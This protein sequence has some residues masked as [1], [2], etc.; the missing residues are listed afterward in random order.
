MKHRLL[1]SMI[2]LLIFI[3]C[4]LT[5][6]G[7]RTAPPATASPVDTAHFQYYVPWD[8][9]ADSII[10]YFEFS[11]VDPGT[12][13]TLI[14]G[15]DTLWPQ[16]GQLFAA[17]CDSFTAWITGAYSKDL[18]GDSIV[19][20]SNQRCRF[21]IE[22]WQDSTHRVYMDSLKGALSKKW[23]WQ[24]AWVHI[25]APQCGF[26]DSILTVKYAGDTSYVY[27]PLKRM[28]RVNTGVISLK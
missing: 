26:T 2:A 14:V 19:F 5:T 15:S 1:L 25:T 22:D 27:Y 6:P 23:P 28:V 11:R 12:D 10:F 3:G 13:D 24:G 9:Y 21:A 20:Q 7:G 4:L 8:N 18:L 16:Y 17:T